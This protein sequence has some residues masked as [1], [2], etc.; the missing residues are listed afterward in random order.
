MTCIYIEYE[1]KE[2]GEIGVSRN[3]RW[4]KLKDAATRKADESILIQIADEDMMA[5]KMKYCINVV[6]KS[7][8]SVPYR[9]SIQ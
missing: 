7:T 6:M 3:R 8:H 1:K 4:G 9:H 5:L 2:I